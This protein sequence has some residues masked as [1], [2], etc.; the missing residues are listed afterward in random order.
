MLVDG[1]EVVR[2]GAHT[3]IDVPR[4]LHASVLGVTG[5]G[6]RGG[7]AM[8]VLVIDDIGL[9]VTC[10]PSLGEGLLGLVEN[11]A[12]VIDGGRVV[13]IEPAGAAGDERLDAEAAA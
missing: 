8:S 5:G 6:R 4:E 2:D 7:C 13:G 11:A 12:L 10:D 9:L 3:S 1:R